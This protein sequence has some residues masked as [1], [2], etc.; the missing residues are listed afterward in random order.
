MSRVTAAW[1]DEQFDVVLAHVLRFGVWL[2]ATVVAAGGVTFLAPHGFEPP[3]YHVFRGEPLPLR[4][5]LGIAAESLDLHGRGLIQFGLLL[6]IATPIARVVFSIA[7]FAR[8]RDWVVRRDHA[9]GAD[10]PR[11]QPPGG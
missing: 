3:S 1:T 8:Q 7:G 5:V 11:L 2:S 10:A 6:L 9:R 4:S